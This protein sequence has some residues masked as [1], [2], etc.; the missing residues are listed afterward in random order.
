MRIIVQIG[1]QISVITCLCST[2][3]MGRW[4][5]LNLLLLAFSSLE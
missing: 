4:P 5:P 1:C 3:K 2:P